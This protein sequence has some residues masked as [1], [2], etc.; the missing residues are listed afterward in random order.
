MARMTVDVPYSQRQGALHMCLT[1]TECASS[2]AAPII[3]IALA[4]AYAYADSKGSSI[5]IT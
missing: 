4:Y 5:R 1:Y 2:Q 3:M